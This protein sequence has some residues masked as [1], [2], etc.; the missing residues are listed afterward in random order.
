MNVDMPS[1]S[2]P[3][4]LIASPFIVFAIYMAYLVFQVI[5]REVV[6]EVVK[7]VVTS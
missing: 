6:I 5:L 1:R 3:A 2:L 7:N 4:V